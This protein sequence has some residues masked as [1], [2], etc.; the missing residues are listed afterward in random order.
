MAPWCIM[1]FKTIISQLGHG[2]TKKV[3]EFTWHHDVYSMQNHDLTSTF[4]STLTLN[5]P[6]FI[7]H[8]WDMWTHMEHSLSSFSL[9][10]HQFIRESWCGIIGIRSFSL[11]RWLSNQFCL[12]W[13]PNTFESCGP[14]AT[15]QVSQVSRPGCMQHSQPSICSST[16]FGTCE[17][18]V[19]AT[20]RSIMA[21]K[22][23]T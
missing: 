14:H 5:M 10:E 23:L 19:R 2:R 8:V 6:M 17:P 21:C 15:I 13:T 4:K 22:T 1:P 12:T 11:H 7:N 9:W 20:L 16:T 3:Y 18:T